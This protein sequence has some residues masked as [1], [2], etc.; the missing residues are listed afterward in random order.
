[1]YSTW[2]VKL[3]IA[4]KCFWY[5]WAM[6]VLNMYAC[7][8]NGNVDY[9]VSCYIFT[10]WKVQLA[11]GNWSWLNCEVM[12]D[13]AIVLDSRSLE[14]SWNCIFAFQSCKSHGIVKSDR[15]H[16]KVVEFWKGYG[17]WWESI[18]KGNVLYCKIL[19]PRRSMNCSHGLFVIWSWKCNGKVMEFY[20]P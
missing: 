20:C 19:S 11:N 4:F 18:Y 6:N 10:L 7:L 14:N 8:L 3:F 17:A 9:Y 13:T 1:M 15:N 12:K 16:G 2:N 5:A